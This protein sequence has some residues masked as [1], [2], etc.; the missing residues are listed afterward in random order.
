[1]YLIVTAIIQ[2]LY[3]RRSR[4]S[5]SLARI[6]FALSA[7]GCRESLKTKTF[8]VKAQTD[9]SALQQLK[10]AQRKFGFIKLNDSAPV[11][12][13]KEKRLIEGGILQLQAINAPSPVQLRGKSNAGANLLSQDSRKTINVLLPYHSRGD[14]ADE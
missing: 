7:T 9:F 5:S 6:E 8:A 13:S 4:A 11:V 12:I 2:Y 10:K 14:L 1:M 3:R